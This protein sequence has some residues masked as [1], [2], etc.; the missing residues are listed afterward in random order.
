MYHTIRFRTERGHC[1]K[2]LSEDIERIISER[3]VTDG[4]CFVFNPHSTAGLFINSYLDPAT[5][6]DI[7]DAVRGLVPVRVDFRHQFDTPTDAAAHIKSVL[8]GNSECIPIEEGTLKMGRSQGVIFAEF[9]GPRE[10]E[11][12]VKILDLSRTGA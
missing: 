9:D 6:E 2:N 3:G 8:F 12:R 10:R 11:I 7:L 4:V 5:P 1:W